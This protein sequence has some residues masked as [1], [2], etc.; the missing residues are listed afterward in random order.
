[1][2]IV[3]E[4]GSFIFRCLGGTLFIFRNPSGKDV[5]GSA[6]IAKMVLSALGAPVEIRGNIIPSPYSEMVRDGKIRS[7]DV[8]VC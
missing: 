7:I 1:V 8:H 3:I 4:A 5:F 2:E 6:Q